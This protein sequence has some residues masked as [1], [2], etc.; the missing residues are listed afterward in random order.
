[1]D[2][3]SARVNL[4]LSGRKLKDLDAFSKSD[5]III[6]EEMRDG[7]WCEVGRTEQ[8]INTLNPDFETMIS[9]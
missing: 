7:K 6:L 5:P 2:H 4:S 1:M 9:M 3:L 8:L